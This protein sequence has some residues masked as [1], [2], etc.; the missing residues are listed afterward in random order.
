MLKAAHWRNPTTSTPDVWDCDLDRICGYAMDTVAP[1]PLGAQAAY[2]GLRFAGCYLW[3]GPGSMVREYAMVRLHAPLVAGQAYEVSL[4]YSRAEGF[5]YAMD[6]V[7]AWFGTDSLQALSP[8]RLDVQPQIRLRSPSTSHLL[9]E[10]SW[11]HIKDTLIASGG[12][13]WL[14][15]GNFDLDEDVDAA[16]ANPSSPYPNAYYFFDDVRVQLLTG[17]G[18]HEASPSAWWDGTG[19]N[20][21]GRYNATQVEYFLWD[22]SGRLLEHFSLMLQ[23]G[24]RIPV[25]ASLRS[26]MYIAQFRGYDLSMTL[27]FVKE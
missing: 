11:E 15:I 7:G 10:D 25:N 5:V 13:Q 16:M 12:E 1:G 24:M 18:I 3:D 21:M 27:R 22:A 8:G 2:E 19:L 23:Q 20:M 14:V 17:S 9:E 26:G 4:R 6:H